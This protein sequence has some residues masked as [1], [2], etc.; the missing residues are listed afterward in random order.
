MV[1]LQFKSF[2][3]GYNPSKEAGINVCPDNNDNF[4]YF[5]FQQWEIRK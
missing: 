1:M 2:T 3:S 5:N 4:N